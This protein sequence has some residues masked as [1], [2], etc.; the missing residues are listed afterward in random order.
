M[1]SGLST[2]LVLTRE[3]GKRLLD[4]TLYVFVGDYSL[5]RLLTLTLC[6]APCLLS[7][8]RGLC[9]AV[10]S[11]AIGVCRATRAISATGT[12]ALLLRSIVRD[13]SSLSLDVY[14]SLA[15][16]GTLATA[17]VTM[18]LLG[19]TGIVVDGGEVDLTDDIEADPCAGSRRAVDLG[20]THGRLFLLRRLSFGSWCRLGLG[21]RLGG[22]LRLRFGLC[23]LRPSVRAW[24]RA[25]PLP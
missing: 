4:L 24:V 20:L 9:I 1:L 2:L 16:A 15:D 19:R 8:A 21:G 18:C 17:L 5:L 22:R 3:A 7:I 6:L 25:S 23:R 13:L 10:S 11:T 12:L 14:R